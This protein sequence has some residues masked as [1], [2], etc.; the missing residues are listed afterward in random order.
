MAE[1]VGRGL[2]RGDGGTVVGANVGIEVG[3]I[4]ATTTVSAAAPLMLPPSPAESWM[5]LVSSPEF[6]DALITPVA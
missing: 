2:G 6:M 4:V 1:V 5:S 3:D